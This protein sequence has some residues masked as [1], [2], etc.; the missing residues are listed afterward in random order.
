MLT[1]TG[2]PSNTEVLK[3]VPETTNI[4]QQGT[5]QERQPLHLVIL[6]ANKKKTQRRQQMKHNTSEAMPPEIP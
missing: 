2:T 4:T 3:C 5:Q 1:S 6:H